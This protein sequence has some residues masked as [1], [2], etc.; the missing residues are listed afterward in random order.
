[1]SSRAIQRNP[2][3][4]KKNQKQTN[5]KTNKEKK[6]LLRAQCS[7]VSFAEEHVLRNPEE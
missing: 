2:D 6:N 4:K 5:K 7:K 1:V 3:L